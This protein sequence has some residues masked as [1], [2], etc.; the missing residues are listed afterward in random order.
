MNIRENV[1][2]QQ[3]R[4]LQKKMEE[5]ELNIRYASE[6]PSLHNQMKMLEADIEKGRR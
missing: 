1:R 6:D 4:E 3:F 5:R 2:K